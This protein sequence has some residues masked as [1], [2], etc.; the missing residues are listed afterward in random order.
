MG[1]RGKSNGVVIPLSL[2][3]EVIS[4]RRHPDAVM[5]EDRGPQFRHV[6]D[7]VGLTE[8]S[9]ELVPRDAISAGSWGTSRETALTKIKPE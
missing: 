4:V 3:L 1:A 5:A 7:V 6:H 2:R 8:E 9:A